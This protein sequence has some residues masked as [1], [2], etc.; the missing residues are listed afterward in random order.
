MCRVYIQLQN[1]FY[2]ALVECRDNN[3]KLT[4]SLWVE[5]IGVNKLFYDM[6]IDRP[7][8]P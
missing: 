1:F 8:R 2:I 5:T 3:Y 4:I 6:L 7:S